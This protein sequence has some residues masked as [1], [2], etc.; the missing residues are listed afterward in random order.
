MKGKD[1]QQS[2][3]TA[4]R[5]KEGP[6]SS[7]ERSQEAGTT[8]PWQLQGWYLCV[9]D[10]DVLSA[11]KAHTGKVIGWVQLNVEIAVRP[12]EWWTQASG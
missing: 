3:D 6:L 7:A 11:Q 8:K 5:D 2:H 9:A 1:L 12:G 4:A 10:A